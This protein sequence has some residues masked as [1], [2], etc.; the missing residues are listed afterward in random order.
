MSKEHTRHIAWNLLLNV[1][2]GPWWWQS[3]YLF[4][5]LPS[6]GSKH[7]QNIAELAVASAYYR[8]LQAERSDCIAHIRR[9]TGKSSSLNILKFIGKVCLGALCLNEAQ[10]WVISGPHTV[11]D[12]KGEMLGKLLSRLTVQPIDCTHKGDVLGECKLTR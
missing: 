1:F 8:L 4:A 10:L 2:P 11:L 3:E 12:L 6:S 7:W 5:S 9:H